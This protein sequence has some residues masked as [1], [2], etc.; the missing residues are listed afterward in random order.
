MAKTLVSIRVDESLVANAKRVLQ[1]STTS[2]TVEKALES[3]VEMERHRRLIV[4]FSGK[5][6]PGD[7]ALS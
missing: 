2:R 3:V 1:T 6:R 5:G 7:F 4:R